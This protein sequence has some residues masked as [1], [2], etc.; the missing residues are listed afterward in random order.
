MKA[1]IF[2]MLLAPLSS[3]FA[4]DWTY[5][6]TSKNGNKQYYK[7]HSENVLFKKIWIKE[8]GSNLKMVNKNNKIVSYSGYNLSLYNVECRDKKIALIQVSHYDINDNLLSTS[9]GNEYK[10]VYVVPGSFGDKIIE[11]ACNQ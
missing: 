5:L 8:E 2:L 1:L 10:L 9:E 4:Q 11:A 6:T 3:L 7:K